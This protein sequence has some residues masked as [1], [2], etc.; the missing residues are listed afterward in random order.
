M[1]RMGVAR[2][3][4]EEAKL[5]SPIT[6]RLRLR[7][8]SR[9][10]PMA[11][12][13]TAL[14]VVVVLTAL[15]RDLPMVSASQAR[16]RNEVPSHLSNT[17][18]LARHFSERADL[19]QQGMR[20]NQQ[21]MAEAEAQFRAEGR[22]AAH[23]AGQAGLRAATPKDVVF[24]EDFDADVDAGPG[25]AGRRRLSQWESTFGGDVSAKCGAVSG[26]ALCFGGDAWK[27]AP[28][29]SGGSGPPSFTFRQAVT[30]AINTIA[31][32][33]ITFALAIAEDLDPASDPTA[34]SAASSG[35]SV[36]FKPPGGTWTALA[37]LTVQNYTEAAA[38]ASSEP[39]PRVLRGEKVFAFG[40]VEL[41]LPPPA[42]SH[43]TKFRWRQF[44]TQAAPGVAEG[45]AATEA[46]PAWALDDVAVRSRDNGGPGVVL[47]AH[48]ESRQGPRQGASA[49]FVV[50]V[51]AHFNTGVRA[52]GAESFE[53]TCPEQEED[54]EEAKGGGSAKAKEECARVVSL[55][56][57]GA[58]LG[59]HMGGGDLFALNVLRGPRPAALRLPEDACTDG[60]GRGNAAS[61]VL[62]FAAKA[63]PKQ[64][65][66]KQ[67][68]PSAPP[69]LAP[70]L[71]D[72]L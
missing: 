3:A 6:H 16:A 29:T 47:S 61:N 58:S 39:R 30:H 43:A 25:Y 21:T 50:T 42:R 66:P 32:D 23:H 64:T 62:H 14:S 60:A 28:L 71:H 35:V 2:E 44:A 40:V 20:Q 26:E 57:V 12:S 72:E 5:R 55:S 18:R 33:R 27:D 51:L 34:S 53:V 37:H 46:F 7:A 10:N 4:R 13:A 67:A 9:H 69:V 8:T 41:T 22:G 54:E 45:S 1:V 38:G 68:E 24:A 36:E 17:V 59:E 70:P 48:S 63:E 19:G 65:E 15:A 11:Q 56:K 31:G 52:L 49:R